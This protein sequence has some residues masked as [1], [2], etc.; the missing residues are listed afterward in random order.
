MR[1]GSFFIPLSIGAQEGGLALIFVSMGMTGD[2][3]LAVSFVRRIKEL[4][5]V[6]FGLIMGWG[7]AFKPAKVQ[8]DPTNGS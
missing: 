4:V 5:W 6:G 3:G 1:V 7:M 8:L 2:V